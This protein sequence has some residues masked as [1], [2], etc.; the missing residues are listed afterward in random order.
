M[1]TAV[2]LAERPSAP[3]ILVTAFVD[4]TAQMHNAGVLGTSSL[5]EGARRTLLRTARS[6]GQALSAEKQRFHVSFRLYRGWYKGWQA[7]DGLRAAGQAVRNTDFATLFGDRID[8]SPAVDYGHTLLAALPDRL[9]RP[10]RQRQSPPIHLPNTLR[11][12]AK[13][14]PPTEKMVDTALAADLLAWAR[15]FPSEWAL[16]LAEDDDVVPPLFTAEAWIKPHGG[17]A[18]L[19]RKRRASQYLKLDGLLRQLP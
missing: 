5:V 16:V 10:E 9:H 2:E 15:Q 1:A 12:Q 7:T 6:V 17:R 13:G 18:L 19:L 14:Q 4:W 8:F 11:N 3:I